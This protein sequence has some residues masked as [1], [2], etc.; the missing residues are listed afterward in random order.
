MKDFGVRLQFSVFLCRLDANGVAHF[1]EKLM[2]VLKA[3]HSEEETD[4]SI[5]IFKRFSSDIADCLPGKR[6][7]REEPLYK[8][9]LLSIDNCVFFCCNEVV[10][11]GWQPIPRDF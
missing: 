3:Y 4:D 11:V 1:R 2:R 5:I 7:V 9:I 10:G 6:I 8:I